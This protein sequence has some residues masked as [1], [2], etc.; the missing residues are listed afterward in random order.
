MS[1][2]ESIFTQSTHAAST[3]AASTHPASTHAAST[4]AA[5]TP[6]A[7]LPSPIGTFAAL[8]VRNYRLFF[9]GQAV[10]NAGTWMQ[11]IAQDWLVLQLT[12]SPLAVGIT[13][14]LQFL[15]MLLLGL[16]GGVLVDRF[17]KRRLL[18]IT[19]SAMGV[20]A[21][22]LAVLTLSGVVQVWQV[23]LI[24][25]GLGLA[26]VVDNPA[27][28]TFVNELVPH[29]LVR[30]AVGLNSGN[31]QLG[32]MLGPALAGVL[33]SAVGVG[34]AF[35]LNA[36]SFV[37]VLAALVAMRPSEFHSMPLAPRGPGQLR[38]GLTY[39]RRTPALLWPIVLVFFVGT[40]GYNFAI[41]LSAYTQNVFHAGANVYGLLNTVMAAGSVAGAL[42]AARRTSASLRL[43]FGSAA[44][45]GAGLIVLGLTPWFVPFAAVLVVVG[46][47][48]VT[49]NTLGNSSVQ[50]ASDP[51]L[52]GRVMSLYMLV[53][54]GGT[55]LGSLLVGWIT[56]VWGAPLALVLCGAVCLVATLVAGVLAARSAGIST[57]LNL[58]RAGLQLASDSRTDCRY[59][60]PAPTR[61]RA[62]ASTRRS[63][64]SWGKSCS[65]PVGARSVNGGS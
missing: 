16:W 22:I 48:S 20:L 26:T 58:H 43:L 18:L 7:G 55:P 52:R 60:T 5:S 24:A 31:F 45:V 10:S 51:E 23:Y 61:M 29:G 47:L 3:H 41:I 56:E 19:Q 4:H 12:N 38:A 49:F 53:F 57:H 63:T 36:L 65:G 1:V 42:M 15:P 62:R 6:A 46:F 8:R 25:L 13:T 11:R 28:Q 54:M 32:R 33:I 34:W 27:R 30:N 39:V 40:F 44:A 2:L 17:P 37:A 64:S 50:L 35:S 21:V 14:A 59:A 9:A